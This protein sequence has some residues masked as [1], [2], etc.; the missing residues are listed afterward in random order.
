MRAWEIVGRKGEKFNREELMKIEEVAKRRFFTNGEKLWIF[1]DECDAKIVQ[2]ALQEALLLE[3]YR[4]RVEAIRVRVY[5]YEAA[6]TVF[7]VIKQSHDDVA[8]VGMQIYVFGLD[9][10]Q[11]RTLLLGH[12]VT[13]ERKWQI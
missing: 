13:V 7:E 11:V 5:T 10:Y 9:L 3:T 6:K 2:E 8:I 12:I 1:G 4:M